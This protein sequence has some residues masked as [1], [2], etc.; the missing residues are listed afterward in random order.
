[1]DP[2][3][4]EPTMLLEE[5]DYRWHPGLCFVTIKRSMNVTPR[6]VNPI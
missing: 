2:P 1:M 6:P 3:Q 5:Y 4:L